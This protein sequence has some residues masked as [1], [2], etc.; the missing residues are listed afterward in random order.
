MQLHC[1]LPGWDKAP[2]RPAIFWFVLSEVLLYGDKLL[3][4]A[5][6][7]CEV[8]NDSAGIASRETAGGFVL[9]ALGFAELRAKVDELLFAFPG[10]VD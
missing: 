9:V 10:C 3:L 4:A 7:R 5:L 8:P 2:A 1:P 6:L